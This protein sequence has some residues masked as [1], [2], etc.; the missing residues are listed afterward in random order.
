ME[1]TNFYKAK[2][3]FTIYSIKTGNDTLVCKIRPFSCVSA[4]EMNF[5]KI[6]FG[7]ST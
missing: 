7:I 3:Q 4:V 6:T 1:I 5:E 2:L